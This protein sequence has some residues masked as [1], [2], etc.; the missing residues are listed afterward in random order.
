[1]N[2]YGAIA[3]QRWKRWRPATYAAIGDPGTYFT[4]LGEEAGNTCR[5]SPPA[6]TPAFLDPRRPD[7]I[8]ADSRRRPGSAEAVFDQPSPRM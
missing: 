5:I 8:A 6:S 2:Q 7:R 3:Q 1:M 4:K